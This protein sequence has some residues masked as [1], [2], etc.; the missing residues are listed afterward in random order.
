MTFFIL[1]TRQRYFLNI[2]YYKGREISARRD[3]EI[4]VQIDMRFT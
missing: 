1:N 3:Q 4:Q 2:F